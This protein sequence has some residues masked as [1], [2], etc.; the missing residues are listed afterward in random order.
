MK[1]LAGATSQGLTL[2]GSASKLIYTVASY[3]QIGHSAVG[4]ARVALM[5]GSQCC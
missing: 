1:L 3:W 5:S 4:T 2:G